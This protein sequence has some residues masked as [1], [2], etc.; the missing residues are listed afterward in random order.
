MAIDAPWRAV[1]LDE[2]TVTRDDGTR[3]A[4]P[5][6]WWGQGIGEFLTAMGRRFDGEGVVL[7]AGV[8]ARLLGL[9]EAGQLPR[10]GL[11]DHPAIE[12]AARAGWSCGAIG[13]WST[14]TGPD[15]PTI[16]LG[17]VHMMDLSADEHGICLEFPMFREAPGSTLQALRLWHDLT[18]SAYYGTPG[19]AGMQIMRALA[20]SNG[21]HGAPTWKPS[22][23]ASGKRLGW[24]PDGAV[25]DDYRPTQ[26]GARVSDYE[27]VHW[28]D[29]N[30]SYISSAMV[31][32]CAPYMLKHTGRTEYSKRLA[33][34]WQIELPHHGGKL[35]W[36]HPHLPHPAGYLADNPVIRWVTHPTMR[37]LT[38]LSTEGIFGGYRILD[39][40]TGPA[41]DSV[42]RPWAERERDAYA[43]LRP[44]G[45]RL[46]WD[47]PPEIVAV[48]RAALK[49]SG[50]QT[51]GY[52]DHASNWAYR[53]DWWYSTVALD[54]C[55]HWRAARKAVN[56][57]YRVAR[58]DV[59]NIA[60]ASNERDPVKAV[61]GVWR[62]ANA[63][64]GSPVL[65]Q[66]GLKL[67]YRKHKRSQRI[68]VKA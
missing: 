22:E 56:D 15:R 48:V 45:S 41:R 4:A 58:I 67:G 62:P 20:P 36:N 1:Y 53:P 39:S 68:R 9:P 61:P 13:D 30:R 19:M 28:Y 3:T 2:T 5:V 16:R 17:L 57:G 44:G 60:V 7:L 65:D 32:E 8:G 12:E 24:G 42:L 25:E 59:D 21:S 50:R 10:G 64:E 26:W 34:W 40:W 55:N 54:R 38:D 18:G 11:K 46:T 6:G 33:G 66:S 63:P 47:P 52:L 37:L 51:L 43:M 14:F 23:T 31:N 27:F 35:A 29:K 49:D